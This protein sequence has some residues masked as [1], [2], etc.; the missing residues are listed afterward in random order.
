MHIQQEVRRAMKKLILEKTVNDSRAVS[1]A[2]YYDE[3]MD[4]GRIDSWQLTTARQPGDPTLR[5][6]DYL[7]QASNHLGSES[8]VVKKFWKDVL[9]KHK[10]LPTWNNG[11]EIAHLGTKTPDISIFPLGISTPSAG[12]FVAAG[13]CKGN[14]WSGTSRGELGQIMSYVHRML[15]AQ[16]ER[17][18][19]Y[20]FVTNNLLFVL[21]KGYRSDTS[22]Y[23][24]RWCISGVLNF[25]AG[26]TLWLEMM[27]KDTGY[28][29]RIAINSFPISFNDTLRPGGT[30]RAFGATYRGETVVA[31]L[32]GDVASATDSASRTKRAANIV[33][34]AESGITQ[35]LARIPHTVA[36]QGCWTLITPK[37]TPLKRELLTTTH[38]EQLVHTLKVVHAA[39]IIHRDVRVSNLFYLSDEQ[40]LLNDWG[41]SVEANE[42]TLYAGS[43]EPHIHPNISPSD[44]YEPHA[45]HDLYSLVS[46]MAMLLVPG[47]NK[48]SRESLFQEAFRAVD[49]IDYESLCEGIKKHM[50]Q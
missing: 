25:E 13:D 2:E 49:Q 19:G 48:G 14:T 5:L 9:S 35:R 32:Y 20:G 18:F 47:I 16:P 42:A 7:R 43:P 4:Q 22:P 12:D 33:S 29:Q 26:M 23:L 41:S 24:V 37:G 3:K 30:C 31:K 11:Y 40:I 34:T 28:H 45:A 39:G 6:P 8:K 36:T 44:F 50:H 38:V 46:S 17:K 15:D 1:Y 10:L 21:V 27:E